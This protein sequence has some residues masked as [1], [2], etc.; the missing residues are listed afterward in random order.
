[1]LG[2]VYITSKALN[3]A[4]YHQIGTSEGTY[5]NKVKITPINL[6]QQA[7]NLTR[8][9]NSDYCKI[10]HILDYVTSIPYVVNNYETNRPNK[11]MD[12]NIGDCDDKSNALISLL[13]VI[14]VEAYFVLVPEHIF[15]VAK[16]ESSRT[17]NQ[18]GLY[19]NGVKYMILES[20]AKGSNIGFPLHYKLSQID[21]IIELF[22]NIK[23]DIKSLDYRE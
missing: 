18:K 20:T 14:G 13:H 9:C 12:D 10:K 4:S 23:V 21:A 5:S 3:E 2:F 7:L 6:R 1:M 15:V 11:T 19:I 8:N 22:E 17:K 16:V